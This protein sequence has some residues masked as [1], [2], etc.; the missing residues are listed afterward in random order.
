MLMKSKHKTCHVDIEMV[1]TPAASPEYSGGTCWR[2]V[3]AAMA[4]GGLTL[5]AAA[6]ANAVIAMR[7][8]P[9]QSALGGVFSRYPARHGD[10]A[11]TVSG[12]GPPLLLLHAPC[13]GNSMAEWAQNFDALSRHFTV[14]ALDYLGWGLSDKP[15]QRYEAED[16]VEQVQYFIEDVIGAPTAVVAS[17]QSSG[18]A[19][20]AAQRAPQ[21]FAS[22]VLVSPAS[23]AEA[24][25]VAYLRHDIAQKALSL[26]IIGTTFY[27]FLVSRRN[28]G[29][30]ALRNLYF[31]QERL[32]PGELKRFHVAAH[33]RGAQAGF[34][35]V[36]SGL[37]D[38][39]WPEAWS[40][41]EAPALI[42]WGRNAFEDG[43]ETA[44]EWLALKSDAD[45]EVFDGAKLLPH[46]EHPQQFNECVIDWLTRH[47]A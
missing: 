21:L 7:T 15:Q 44:P 45:L 40:H 10:L 34:L 27:N 47:Q 46:E 42:I 18:I 9:L 23:T 28:I 31:D 6:A 37:L 24:D 25:D 19:L 26:P 12:T 13:A 33:Q 35:S 2:A 17:A 43:L 22:L 29:H 39:E 38:V 11:Y 5:G 36:L 8:P 3:K 30:F 4:L 14:Y 1:E 20:K 32:A 16:L 41:F